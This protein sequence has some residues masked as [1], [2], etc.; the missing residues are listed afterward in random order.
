M[1]GSP[2]GLGELVNDSRTWAR[3]LVAYCA[4][5]RT[6]ARELIRRHI[7]FVWALNAA[8]RHDGDKYFHTYLKPEE[9]VAVE[10]LANVPNGI[11]ALQ[12]REV[13]ARE[14]AGEI[15]GF[16]FLGLAGLLQNISNQMGK[17]ERIRN[18]IFPLM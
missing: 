18:T 6:R 10:A 14:R 2:H 13:H 16:R 11:L 5:D 17:S 8:L 9:V 3:S 1:V 15:D 12:T 4:S 7:A